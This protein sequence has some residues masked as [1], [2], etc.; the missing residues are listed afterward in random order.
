MPPAGYWPESY[1]YAPSSQEQYSLK[2][3]IIGSSWYP[4]SDL[5]TRT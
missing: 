1:P 3:I 5:T 2:P 4:T